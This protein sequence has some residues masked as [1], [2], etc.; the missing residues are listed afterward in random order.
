M[1]FGM[2]LTRTKLTE[3]CTVHRGQIRSRSPSNVLPRSLRLSSSFSFVQWPLSRLDRLVA[4]P[5]LSERST[6]L[7]LAAD[8]LFDDLSQLFIRF[9]FRQFA[10]LRRFHDRAHGGHELVRRGVKV[11]VA[12]RFARLGRFARKGS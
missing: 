10:S 9:G 4:V 5:A 6:C 7:D 8:D 11:G 3:I 12:E 1:K 2:S